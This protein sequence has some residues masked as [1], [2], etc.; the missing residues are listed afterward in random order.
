MKRFF[1]AIVIFSGFFFSWAAWKLQPWMRE[2]KL[3]EV[4]SWKYEGYEFQVWQRKNSTL[5]EPF[6]TSL[7]VRHQTNA[8]HQYYLNHQDDYSPNIS[9]TE[10]DSIVNVCRGAKFLGAY[11]MAETNYT[12]AGGGVCLEA[13]FSENPPGN[14]DRAN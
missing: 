8:W 3:I 4:G 10:K 2:G 5:D 13:V 9:L 6:S 11:N 14:R 12:R 1:I 7:Y